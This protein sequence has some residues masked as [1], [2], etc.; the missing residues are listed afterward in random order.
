MSKTSLKKALCAILA[1]TMSTSLLAACGK[2]GGGSGGVGEK[3]KDGNVTLSI[4]HWENEATSKAMRTAFDQFEKDH[5]KIKVEIKAAPLGDYGTKLSQMIGSGTAPDIF[6]LGHDMGVTFFQKGL[7]YDFTDKAKAEP[8]LASK[9]AAGTYDKWSFA[10]GDKKWSGK[11]FGLPGLLNVYGVFYNKDML[12]KAGLDNPTNGWTWDDLYTYAE[13]LKSKGVSEY[14]C[15]GMTQ[16]SFWLAMQSVSEGGAELSTEFLEPQEIVMDQKLKDTILK[17]Q[18]H[19]KS[20]ALTPPTYEA[21]NIQDIFRQGQIPMLFY[22]QWQIA[23]FINNPNENLN[24]DYVA[25]PKGSVKQTVL[26]DCTGWGASKGIKAPDE[27]WELMKF[28][29]GDMYSTVLADQ[30]V[31][32]SAYLDSADAFYNKVK[33]GGHEASAEAVKYMLECESK[34]MLR[35][36]PDW[37]DQANKVKDAKWNEI[38]VGNVDISEVDNIATEINKIIKDY[39]DKAAAK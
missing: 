1:V 2:K 18:E 39:N 5:E 34:T 16:D 36:Y 27:V 23:D 9:Y 31:A 38:V 35:F 17:V 32:A 4:T 25:N 12:A 15:Y 11:T 28:C 29:S 6:Q 20:G 33:D 3:D 30:P 10:E 7:L 19:I 22:G 21:T 14:G 26:Y 37:K 24:W 8:D 13:T